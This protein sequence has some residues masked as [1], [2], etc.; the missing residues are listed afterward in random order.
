MSGASL[1]TRPRGLAI[2]LA[3]LVGLNPLAI[4]TYL[5]ALPEIAER[6]ASPLQ[7]IELSISTYLVGYSVG[8]LMAAPLSDRYGRR[9]L[10]IFG[11]GL[12]AIASIGVTACSNAPALLGVRF[13]QA[14]GAGAAIVNVGAIIRDFYDEHDSARQLSLIGSIM[15]ILPLV[16]PAVG[17]GILAIASWQWIFVLFALYAIV[18]LTVSLRV[19]PETVTADNRPELSGS[20]WQQL[21]AHVHSVLLHRRATAFALTASFSSACLFLYLTDAAFVYMDYFSI[22][23]TGFP[24]Y[25]G[26]AVIAMALLHQLNLRLLKTY[27]PRRILPWGIAL[28]IA[29]SGLLFAYAALVDEPRLAAYVAGITLVLGSQTLIANNAIAAYMSRFRTNAGMANA[30]AASATFTLGAVAS[31]VLTVLHD[32]T[33]RSLAAGMFVC[34]LLAFACSRIALK[35]DES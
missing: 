2:V 22:T 24:F 11:L 10:L 7:T 20:P 31:V 34:A 26:A 1:A 33:P 9:P 25:F 21:Q 19:L 16:A 8:M 5:P 32:G 30:I 14:F 27:P 18:I 28:L 29:A 17:A 3:C 12:F 13:I 15:L 23:R 4:D 35:L 6:L